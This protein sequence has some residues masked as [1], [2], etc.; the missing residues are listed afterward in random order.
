MKES[1]EVVM[2]LDRWTDAFDDA[3]DGV[4]KGHRELELLIQNYMIRGT[5]KEMTVRLL[6][7]GK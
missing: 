7:K 1:Y 5:V 3:M 6:E 4:E 2:R